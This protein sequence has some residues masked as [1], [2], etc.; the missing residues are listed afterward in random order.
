MKF[1]YYIFI[2]LIFAIASCKPEIDEFSPSNGDAE[3]TSFL[4]VGNSLTAGYADGA[5]YNSGQENSFP[6]ILA[7]QFSYVGG[8]DFKQPMMVD[9]YGFG[10]EG[11]VPVPKLVLGASTD[12]MDVTSLAPVRADVAVNPA[13]FAS[14]AAE[15]PYNNI[16]VPGVK[17]THF[18]TDLLATLNPYYARFA[19]TATTPLINL[20]AAIDATFF[21]LW[22]GN[23]DALGYALAGGAADALTPP[24]Q[25]AVAYENILKAC[26]QNQDGAYA[27]AKG[28]L[29]N[30]PDIL[31]IPYCNYMSTKVPYNGLV[32]TAEQAAGLELLYG[33]YG[34]PD[35]VFVE[36]QNPWVVQNSDGS[37]G[38]MSAND[39][40]LLSL[41]TDS[42]QCFG[43]GVAN[44]NTQTPYPI[45]HQYILDEAEI[46]DIRN[47]VAAYNQ[48]IYD[49]ATTYNMVY[50]DMAQVLEDA[51]SPGIVM[52][53][54]TI[55]ST[56]VTGNAFSLDGIHLTPLGNAMAAH[57]F[58]DGINS[59]YGA[60]IPQVLVTNYQAVQF[61]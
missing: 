14:V 48:T 1:K 9:D 7:N 17:S 40:F 46:T 45:P 54:I 36:G 41:P 60:S 29:A 27:P 21:T 57:Y 10:F 20:T 16:G 38:R 53:G 3:F 26:I 33:L 61:P 55:T 50:V 11:I 6:N 37:W 30:I 42:M 2:L 52:D 32:L 25:F 5:L 23:N 8:G 51:K 12:C 49:L 22:V 43:M 18:F 56:F 44:P 13:N 19:P 24:A 39:Q 28:A 4:A 47:H 34:Y 58:I 15:G 35:F 59:T 31:S